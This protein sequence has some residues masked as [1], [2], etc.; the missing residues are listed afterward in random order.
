MK[1][2]K[3]I[4][5]LFI[6]IS[7]LGCNSNSTKNSTVKISRSQIVKYEN[8]FKNL[9]E[10]LSK[11][12]NE[13][14]WNHKLYGPLFFVNKDNRIIIANEPDTKGILSKDDGIYTGIL[15]KRINIANSPLDW[16]G[17]RWAMVMLPLPKNNNERLNL[18]IHELFHRIQPAISFNY[19]IC[20]FSWLR[21]SNFTPILT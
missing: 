20:Y 15:P 4:L 16:N 3:K 19:C 9:K 14:L 1:N 12:E 5:V 17:K 6:T 18:I 10:Y 7:L 8:I 2:I 21:N 13:K 11:K